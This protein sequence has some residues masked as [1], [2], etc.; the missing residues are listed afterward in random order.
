MTAYK[1]ETVHLVIPYLE[2][3]LFTYIGDDMVMLVKHLSELFYGVA[4]VDLGILGFK[5]AGA[6]SVSTFLKASKQTGVSW[7][8]EFMTRHMHLIVCTPITTS[9]ERQANF[10]SHIG[11]IIN[12][13]CNALSRT[14]F[15]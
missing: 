15:A 5:L 9:I 10:N 7:I 8:L 4:Q 6:S 1:K 13:L 3:F 12:Y 14:I 2:Y 11:N